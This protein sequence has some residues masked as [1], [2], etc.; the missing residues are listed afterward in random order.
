MKARRLLIRG[1][2]QG[3]GF[4]FFTE[5]TARN[6]GLRG[7]VRNLADGRVEV[8]A[9]GSDDD[10]ESFVGLLRRGPVGAEVADI[11]ASDTTLEDDVGGFTIR[12]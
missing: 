5:R 11:E 7:H 2:V 4:R 1:L 3:V 8:V 9:A 12:H 6:L 10:L